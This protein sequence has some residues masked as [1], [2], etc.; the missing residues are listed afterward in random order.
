MVIAVYGLLRRLDAR[1]VMFPEE[2]ALLGSVNFLA[3]LPR[4]ELEQLARGATWVDVP[5]GLEVI[6]Q[7]DP[8]DRYYVIEQGEFTVSIDGVALTEPLVRGE[9]FGEIALL[10]SVPRTASV[11]ARTSGR[12]L[13]L[14]SEDFL[15][16]VTGSPDGEARARELSLQNRRRQ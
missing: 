3:Q 1:A 9:G 8:G 7:G 10:W 16:A 4:Y 6:R 12:L 14:E 11:T 15:A 5:A 13:A 2:T